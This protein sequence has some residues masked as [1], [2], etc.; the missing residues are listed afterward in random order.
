MM[1]RTVLSTLFLLVLS[2]PAMAGTA[3]ALSEADLG[4]L[5]DAIFTGKGIDFEIG[6]NGSCTVSNDCGPSPTISCSSSSGNCHSGFDWVECDG[7]RTYCAPSD[8]CSISTSCP[9]GGGVS[10]TGSAS[11]GCY[12]MTGCWVE[13]S[14]GLFR[15]PGTNCPI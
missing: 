8:T 4:A 3:P 9:G 7:V 10:C 13:C 12:K 14:T 1:K 11:Y 2:V 5:R 15:C 6:A